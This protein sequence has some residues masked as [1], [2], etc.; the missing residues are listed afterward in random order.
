LLFD[1]SHEGG[2]PSGAVYLRKMDGA[3]PVRLGDGLAADLSPDGQWAATVTY[4]GQLSL[5]PVGAGEARLLR[6][7]GLELHDARFFPDGRRVLALANEKNHT[8]RLF[9]RDL[10]DA[11]T[12]KPIAPEGV[13]ALAISPDGRLV[14]GWAADGAIA[15]YP[16]DGESRPVPHLAPAE[17]PLRWSKDAKSLFISRTEG[18]TAKIIRLD[19]STGRREP[20]YE[21]HPSDVAGS[22][23]PQNIHLSADGRTYVYQV[24]HYLSSLYVVDGLR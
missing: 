22:H 18:L 9:I 16:T 6:T 7:E 2:G 14:A 8:P 19:L 11:G 5:L 21:I 24:G 12:A 15:F 13:R 4:K 20:M 3:P 10:S 1:E 23:G 17:T